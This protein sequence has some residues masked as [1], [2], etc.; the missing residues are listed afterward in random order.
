MGN[1]AIKAPVNSRA[2]FTALEEMQFSLARAIMLRDGGRITQLLS[3]PML[4]INSPLNYGAEVPGS[5]PKHDNLD[6]LEE[7]QLDGPKGKDGR[8]TSSIEFPGGSF[9]MLAAAVGDARTASMLLAKGA[10]ANAVSSLDSVTALMVASRRGDVTIVALLLAHGKSTSLTN[11][12]ATATNELSNNSQSKTRTNT[13]APVDVNASTRRTGDTALMLA[14]AAGHVGVVELLC[15]VIGCDVHATR[16]PIINSFES[17]RPKADKSASVDGSGGFPQTASDLAAANGHFAVVTYLSMFEAREL[18]VAGEIMRLLDDDGDDHASIVEFQKWFRKNCGGATLTEEELLL[19]QSVGASSTPIIEGQVTNE[20]VKVDKFDNESERGLNVSAL[21]TL[22]AV[23][24]HQ[25]LSRSLRRVIERVKQAEAAQEGDSRAAR[26]STREEP[27]PLPKET[28]RR[29]FECAD[30][31]GDGLITA[32]D[33]WQWGTVATGSI[34]AF[35]S[36]MNDLGLLFADR[37]GARPRPPPPTHGG[38]RW[39][40]PRPQVEELEGQEIEYANDDWGGNFQDNSGDKRKR[41]SRFSGTW[42]TKLESKELTAAEAAA[43]DAAEAYAAAQPACL[44]FELFR[45]AC[46]RAPFVAHRLAA[47]LPAFAATSNLYAAHEKASEVVDMEEFEHELA[48][49]GSGGTLD[50]SIKQTPKDGHSSNPSVLPSAESSKLKERVKALKPVPKDRRQQPQY[51]QHLHENV[52]GDQDGQIDEDMAES[53]HVG[54]ELAGRHQSSSGGNC[55]VS[56]SSGEEIAKLRTQLA[57]AVALHRYR[58]QHSS[59]SLSAGADAVTTLRLLLK[60]RLRAVQAHAA[61]VLGLAACLDIHILRLDDPSQLVKM[62]RS[63]T[64]AQQVV[65]AEHDGACGVPCAPESDERRISWEGERALVLVKNFQEMENE[66][67]E[68]ENKDEREEDD[69]NN[70]RNENET[71]SKQSRRRTSLSGP[72][73]A[74][75]EDQA[76]ARLLQ[77]V[78]TNMHS[79]F[80]PIAMKLESIRS[81]GAKRFQGP[82]VVLPGPRYRVDADVRA[83][84]ALAIFPDLRIRNARSAEHSGSRIHIKVGHGLEDELVA[85]RVAQRFAYCVKQW[86]ENG[87]LQ[88]MSAGSTI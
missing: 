55:T 72:W 11:T 39:L 28:I 62:R 36:S 26:P 1:S 34:H 4:D 9:L 29:I 10:D 71:P 67:Y 61:L 6:L 65:V 75:N 31:D 37:S 50:D 21:R 49:D 2:N 5:S 27:A 16:R 52:V 69:E 3:L 82:Y 13:A 78:P 20:E 88:E 60:E 25:Q 35:S 59:S 12:A 15:D 33:L 45:L 23:P 41:K 85:A 24:E 40:K 77:L 32:E 42:G 64:L 81:H 83:D 74:I 66:G 63:Y 68:E 47:A 58:A 30:A 79:K 38:L 51:V 73:A 22:L 57:R 44:P 56:R 87:D 43:T 8:P 14:A 86:E 48:A 80:P 76:N 84:C 46:A 54:V 7:G 18:G 70:G 19:L 17:H 53:R